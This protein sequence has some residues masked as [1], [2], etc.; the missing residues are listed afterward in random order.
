M[1]QALANVG[2]DYGVI[3]VPYA[4]E[5]RHEVRA[6]TG[7]DL[8]PV[9]IDGD[10]VVADSRRIVAYLY[11]T[12]GDTGQQARAAELLDVVPNDPLISALGS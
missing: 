10:V 1:R 4:R 8:T 11:S 6:T 12:Y 2:Q 7:Q 9:L 5:D 3:Q